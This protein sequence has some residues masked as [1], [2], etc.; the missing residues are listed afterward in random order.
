MSILFFKEKK[1]IMVFRNA[2]MESIKT[3]GLFLAIVIFLTLVFLLEVNYL[4]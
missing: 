2:N 3:N 4:H 1:R